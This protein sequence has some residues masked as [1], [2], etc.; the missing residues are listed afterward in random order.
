MY[1]LYPVCCQLCVM[2]KISSQPH[3]EKIYVYKETLRFKNILDNHELPN[4]MFSTT[5]SRQ[6]SWVTSVSTTLFYMWNTVL[7][8]AGFL[9]ILC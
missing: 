7:T 5:I 4:I 6:H 2:R 3:I 1:V 8:H 9:S